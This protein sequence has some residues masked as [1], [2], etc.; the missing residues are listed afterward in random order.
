MAESPVAV[1]DRLAMTSPPERADTLLGTACVIGA[2][3]AGLLA[4]RVLADHAERVVVIER[5]LLDGTPGTRTSVPQRR[6]LHVLVPGGRA[7]LDR[8]LPGFTQEVQDGGAVLVPPEQNKSYHDGRLLAPSAYHRLGASR[9]FLE[10]TVRDRVL[11]LP[12]ISVLRAQATGLRY[13]GDTVR[14]VRYL[15]E[16]GPEVRATD[17]VVDATGRAGKLADWLAEGGFDRPALERLAAPINY[18]TALFRRPQHVDELP[19]TLAAARNS[20]SY[21]ADE[22]AMAALVAIEDGQW[23]V[24]LIGHDDARPGRTLDAFRAACAKLPP[25]FAEA[26]ATD[27][28][29][30][31]SAYRQAES[32]RR[33]FAVLGH[34]PARLVS[35]GDAMASFNPVYG[36]GMTSAALHAS[37]L[38]Q[39]LRTSPDLETAATAFFGLQQVVVDAAWAVSAGG[40][41]A[42]LDARTG[43]KVPA[44]VRLQREAMAQL[45]L[46][47]RTDAK[48]SRAIEDVTWMLA[49]PATLADPG[50]LEQA[51]AVNRQ[52]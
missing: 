8:W 42:R 49:H 5:D 29:D 13:E 43:A 33:D 25:P 4:A 26:A 30:G 9:T 6:H 47:A 52:R 48:V 34:L 24:T 44:E 38:S 39:Y 3:V 12:N 50:L 15:S 46:A 32:R 36:Q 28:V 23:I 10:N 35:V 14:G 31:I 2:S 45:M 37:C 7:W 1:F 17:F 27:P 11:G 20:P 40:D 18:S 16:S 22:V 19:V 21:T 51:L 41:A